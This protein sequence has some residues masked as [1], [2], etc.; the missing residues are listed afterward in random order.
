MTPLALRLLTA[1]ALFLP[2]ASESAR[3]IL[4]N[5][6][7]VRDMAIVSMQVPANGIVVIVPDVIFAAEFEIAAPSPVPGATGPPSAGSPCT[8]I[9]CNAAPRVK[10]IR[11][12]Q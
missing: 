4:V 12:A 9:A 5:G 1:L 7:D 2:A 10:G 8:G 3:L 11:Q 6:N